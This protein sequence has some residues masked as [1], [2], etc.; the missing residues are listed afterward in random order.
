VI[1]STERQLVLLSCAPGAVMLLY[2]LFT[3]TYYSPKLWL[4]LGYTFAF[5]TLTHRRAPVW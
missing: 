4:P 1:D 5:L 3:T 2:M